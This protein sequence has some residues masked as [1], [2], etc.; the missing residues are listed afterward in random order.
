MKLFPGGR[1]V[2]MFATFFLMGLVHIFEVVKPK[3]RHYTSQAWGKMS[4]DEWTKAE[5]LR[6][7]NKI[8]ERVK[9]ANSLPVSGENLKSG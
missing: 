6:V 7:R 1:L 3:R 5:Q 9:Q 2:G 4:R 8:Y